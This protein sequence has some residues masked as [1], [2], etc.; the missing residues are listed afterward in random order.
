MGKAGTLHLTN[1]INE[2]QTKWH[3]YIIAFSLHIAMRKT[4]FNEALG[5]R[6]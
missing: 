4:I 5:A 1:L 6:I 3:I 2:Y